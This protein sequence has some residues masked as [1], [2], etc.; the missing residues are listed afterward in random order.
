MRRRR[1]T[2]DDNGGTWDTPELARGTDRRALT[3]R[4]AVRE[5]EDGHFTCCVNQPPTTQLPAL[6]H[7]L[8]LSAIYRVFI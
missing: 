8:H 2:T 5:G 4:L 6:L 7:L 3:A 1:T